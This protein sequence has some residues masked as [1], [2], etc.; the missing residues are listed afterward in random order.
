MAPTIVF[1]N[2][3]SFKMIL[4]DRHKSKDNKIISG[5]KIFICDSNLYNT[6]QF[7]NKYS[8]LKSD[9]Q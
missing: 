2:A 8:H 6:A 9:Y 7:H 1:N 4:T 3:A 5:S